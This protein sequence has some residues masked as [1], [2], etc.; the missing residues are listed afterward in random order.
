MMAAIQQ[1]GR[2]WVAATGEADEPAGYLMAD[3]VD[4]C[5]HVE[6]VSVDPDSARRGLGRALR[7]A[8]C[9]GAQPRT[10]LIRVPGPEPSGRGAA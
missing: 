1:S 3:M 9:G 2:L 8:A 4:S 7:S 6:Q 10:V 5:L